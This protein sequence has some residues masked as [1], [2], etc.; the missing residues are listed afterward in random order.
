MMPLTADLVRRPLALWDNGITMDQTP[1]DATPVRSDDRQ[2]RPRRH[3]MDPTNLQAH[4]T[5][6]RSLTTVQKWVMS[7]L[8]TTT[9]LH[10]AVGFVIAA[11]HVDESRTDAQVGLLCIGGAFGMIAIAV[12]VLIHQRRFPPRLAPWLLLGWLP[13]VVGAAMLFG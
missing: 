8:V 3:L 13:S 12:G 4:R 7:T 10:L 11:F 9:I 2:P 6:Q 1:P 5:T